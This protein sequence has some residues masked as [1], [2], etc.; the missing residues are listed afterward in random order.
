ME[1]EMATQSSILVRKIPWTEEPGRLWS[2]GSQTVKTWLKRWEHTQNIR[3]SCK[4]YTQSIRRVGCK[5][6]LTHTHTHT[7]NIRAS[8]KQYTQSIRRVGCKQ[9]HTHTHTHTQNIRASC[10]QYTQ[11]IRRVGCKQSLSLSL[12]HTHTHTHTHGLRRAGCR[13]STGFSLKP[14]TFSHSLFSALTLRVS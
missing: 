7:Q 8:C 10:K 14:V 9:S 3:A 2:T 13:V 4:Q 11:S 5:Q 6:S 1:R 12:T